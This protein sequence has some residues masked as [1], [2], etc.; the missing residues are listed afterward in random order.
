MAYK[1]P[2]AEAA[3]K[4]RW[5]LDNQEI[6]KQ[7]AQARRERVK[8]ENVEFICY[9]KEQ[10]PCA[11]CD[12]YYPAVC[13]DF[14]HTADDKLGNVSNMR[15]WSRATLMTEIDKCEIVCACCHRLRTQ[16][17]LTSIVQ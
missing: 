2:V 12:R 10:T 5:Y 1:D 13:M 14:D 9:L 11:D 4:K 15:T 17:R 8:Q 6:T 16:A 3:A 7:R